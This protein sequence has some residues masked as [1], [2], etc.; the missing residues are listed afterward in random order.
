MHEIN[1]VAVI[2]LKIGRSLKGVK[3][4]WKKNIYLWKC[5]IQKLY[6]FSLTGNQ[7][8]QVD[9]HDPLPVAF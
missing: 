7:N 8:N 5:T 4:F 1:I 2:Q 9:F 6:W 3:H